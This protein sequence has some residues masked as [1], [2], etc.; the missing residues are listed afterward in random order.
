MFIV[1]FLGAISISF[2]IWGADD[3]RTEPTDVFVNYEDRDLMGYNVINESR[4]D[5]SGKTVNIA[6][7]K[8]LII[9]N[10][11][12]NEIKTENTENKKIEIT[13]ELGLKEAIEKTNGL[14]YILA[15]VKKDYMVSGVQYAVF[16]YN[17]MEKNKIEDGSGIET[18]SIGEDLYSQAIEFEKIPENNDNITITCDKALIACDDI[19]NEYIIGP[20]SIEYTK[21]DKKF[22]KLNVSQLQEKNKGIL[23]NGIVGA[24]LEVLKEGKSYPEYIDNWSFIFTEEKEILNGIYKEDYNLYPNP[25]ENFYIK[26]PYSENVIALTKFVFEMQTLKAIAHYDKYE[27]KETTKVTQNGVTSSS[28]STRTDGIYK[29]KDAKIYKEFRDID[30]PLGKTDSLK[31]YYLYEVSKIKDDPDIKM[32][33]YDTEWENSEFP[34]NYKIVMNYSEDKKA[35]YKVEKLWSGLCIP[36]TMSISGNVWLDGTE[37]AND[38]DGIMDI[39]NTRLT[40][41]QYNGKDTLYAILCDYKTGTAIETCVVTAG[42]YKFKYVPAGGKKYY[43]EFAYD[44]M[45][46]KTTNSLIP[47]NNNKCP[48]YSCASELD[49]DRIEFNKHFYEITTN[50]GIY[51]GDSPEKGT[52]NTDISYTTAPVTGGQVSTVQPF[53]YGNS[54]IAFVAS[55][56]N[57][58]RQVYPVDD[59]YTVSGDINSGLPAKVEVKVKAET[60][61]TTKTETAS[62]C[63][64]KFSEPTDENIGIEKTEYKGKKFERAD[65]YLPCINLGLV[66]RA[67]GDFAVKAD[68]VETKTTYFYM[69][70]GDSLIGL[71]RKNMQDETL[72]KR[73]SGVY[74]QG[75]NYY[76]D[77]YMQKL[78]GINYRTRY[79]DLENY[80][81]TEAD[82]LQVFVKYQIR[83]F[84]QSELLSGEITE[85]AAHYDS[86][87]FYSNDRDDY[88]EGTPNND[89]RSYQEIISAIG[90][91]TSYAQKFNANGIK[92]TEKEITWVEEKNTLYTTALDTSKL[93]NND[94]QLKTGEYIDVYIVFKVNRETNEKYKSLY[95]EGKYVSNDNSDYGKLFLPEISG[96]RVYNGDEGNGAN[97]GKVDIDSNPG[98]VDLTKLSKTE[99]GYK[100][101]GKTL[102]DDTDITAFLRLTVNDEIKKGITG[103][104]WEDIRELDEST[105]MKI[106]NGKK[107]TESPKNELLIDNVK[108]EAIP[109]TLIGDEFIETRF[110]K[111]AIIAYTGPNE[112]NPNTDN[113]IER[114]QYSFSKLPSGYYKIRFTYGAEKQLSDN[115]KYNGHDY[116][117]TNYSGLGNSN[118]QAFYNIT[119]MT[120]IVDG[121]K[122]TKV[123]IV[124][125]HE[126]NNILNSDR[127]NIIDT[128]EVKLKDTTNEI[129]YTKLEYTGE[130][131]FKN[132]N[133]EK[134]EN[135][136][137]YDMKF[138]I[139]I[140]DGIGINKLNIAKLNDDIC[141]Y[142]IAIGNYPDCS[143]FYNENRDDRI[144]HS[145]YISTNNKA[146]ENAYNYIVD[147]IEERNLLITSLSHA[148]D[149]PYDRDDIELYKLDENGNRTKYNV[150]VD[151]RANVMLYSQTIN[152]NMANKL[153]VDKSTNLSDFAVN[154]QMTAESDIIFIDSNGDVKTINL[155]LEERPKSNIELE[156]EVSN[157][158]IRTQSND[159]IINMNVGRIDNLQHLPDEY[160]AYLD[161][162]IMQGASIDVEYAI[163]VKNLGEVDNFDNYVKYWPDTEKKEFYKKVTGNDISSATDNELKTILTRTIPIRINQINDYYDNLV[164]RAEDNVNNLIN[165]RK[166]NTSEER[167]DKNKI[168]NITPPIY[169]IDGKIT[170]VLCG[171]YDRRK[172]VYSGS[173][174]WNALQTVPTTPLL[175]KGVTTTSLKTVDIYP[176][177]SNEAIKNREN[178]TYN[179]AYTTYLT[180]SKTLSAKDP[181]IR[182]MLEYEN[183]AEIME[184]FSYTGRR[185]YDSKVGNLKYDETEKKFTNDSEIDWNKAERVILLPP[186][187]EILRNYII[188]ASF[189]ILGIIGIVLISRVIRKKKNN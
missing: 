75:N 126:N 77:Y 9:E 112:E 74:N 125:S 184:T 106:G 7:E 152:E 26:I 57:T 137:D 172:D 138:V 108:V 88:Y 143:I 92:V 29:I 95:G 51:Y 176:A 149:L 86:D 147:I 67:A 186:F 93:E 89:S 98:N 22:K 62:Y 124:Y 110:T 39:K 163:T 156:E 13:R 72:D 76:A 12:F 65:N 79:N 94:F 178:A 11:S 128:L 41:E 56:L 142:G 115:K 32:K 6:K 58:K 169:D 99:D 85:L 66:E 134:D 68:I 20:F 162:E 159:Q 188:E 173:V 189:V 33:F 111:E 146:V 102:E 16:R 70:L 166:I 27:V 5:V 132:I 116:K 105:N 101:L 164:F 185:C 61:T 82:E 8:D 119:N 97:A 73:D 34:D 71:N 120:N 23:F 131:V 78:D 31:N 83:I 130:T 48:Y 84:N 90:N 44:V 121:I 187:G 141:V 182:G 15:N 30:V 53:V 133:T 2:N 80:E 104:V 14:A 181:D 167:N 64:I 37:V 168:I 151:G 122:N 175:D 117:S 18:P 103:Y 36:L 144:Q 183:Y 3:P 55:T 153:D 46:Y 28:T 179:A 63:E 52:I 109:F 45:K 96:Y 21:L 139:I 35:Q 148:R 17:G 174:Q 180:L 170:R 40:S 165:Y 158:T 1:I 19:N 160:I 59:V 171:E 113:P 107:E 161:K 49:S 136:D 10:I 135:N 54:N 4:K 100:N 127:N 47:N 123:Y 155:G 154:T 91:S 129:K 38:A 157:I 118:N 150:N 177:M 42:T 43:V 60:G 24:K 87:Y 50:T 145:K 140:T 25:N 81:V 69:D 114:G